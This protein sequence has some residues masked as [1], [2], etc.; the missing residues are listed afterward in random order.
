MSLGST[1]RECANRTRRFVKTESKR[2]VLSYAA[3]TQ[4]LKEHG[5]EETKASITVKLNQCPDRGGVFSNDNEGDWMRKF[6]F[7]RCLKVSD[8]WLPA[9]MVIALIGAMFYVLH[10]DLPQP[11]A[12]PTHQIDN[13]SGGS[14]KNNKDNKGKEPETIWQKITRD[15][16]AFTTL[17]LTAVTGI[18]AASTMGL[19]IVTARSGKRQSQDMKASIRIAE[20]ALIEVER[21]FVA[22]RDLSV[23]T[24]MYSDNFVAAFNIPINIVNS[25]RTPAVRYVTNHTVAVFEKVPDDFRFPDRMPHR[26]GFNV[27]G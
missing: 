1:E 24:I 21:A 11:S 3:L 6:A 17:C 27:I 26:P 2:A 5:L 18:L 8:R 23:T 12:P 9:A 4:R 16:V 19:W 15:P 13:Q 7:G 22:V 14:G 20:R 10:T 25:G